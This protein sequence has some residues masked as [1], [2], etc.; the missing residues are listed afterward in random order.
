MVNAETNAMSALPSL[1]ITDIERITLDVPF[2]P[3][4]EY[5]NALL[6]R[7]WRVVEICRVTTEG[8]FV[9]YGETLPHYTWAKV[10]DDA[11]HRAKGKN[12]AALLSDDSL[13]AGLQ[14][15][16]FDVVGKALNVPMHRLLN[17]PQ[18][19][20]W[21]PIAW[22][23]HDM[24]PEALAEEAQ[25]AVAA[26][27]LS[28]KF[29]TRPWLD[30]FAQVEAV[31]AVTPASYRIDVDWNDMLLNV[32]NAAPILQ[33][34]DNY[35]RIAIYEGPIPQRDIEGY[36]HLRR[37][38]NRPIAIHFG[39]PPFATC[40]HE[41]MC[42]G[43][44]MS[45]GGAGVMRMAAQCAAFDKP[46]WLQMV[47]TGLTTA[48]CAHFGAVLTHAQWP[49]ITC[50]NNYADDLLTEPHTIQNG[51]I[52]VPEAPGLGVTFDESTVEKYR[53]EPPY[54][55]EERKNIISV[56]WP[57][58]KVV[59][60]ALMAHR[61]LAHAKSPFA[62]EAYA[63]FPPE[64]GRQCWEDFL[65]GNHPVEVRGVQLEVRLDDGTAEWSDLYERCLRGPVHERRQ[66]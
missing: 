60:F 63:G 50:M 43:F 28:H 16:L 44:V 8:G 4:C 59:H 22:W 17:Q 27:Y 11:V 39:L 47:G 41:E 65:A 13:G 5:W 18:V 48:W 45:H 37:K 33:E 34:L 64:V 46:F 62:H 42:D 52:R 31:S 23:N 54:A 20:E 55:L 26:G 12:A 25:E 58:G 14:M 32:G 35:E 15:A 49:A 1:K 57:S 6:V 30:P 53:M 36:K 56:V 7:N 3:R 10:T 29:K 21:C 40:V 19:R 2:T 9:G 61:Q 51:L 24:S 38:T 66:V